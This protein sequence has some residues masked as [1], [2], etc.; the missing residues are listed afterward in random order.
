MSTAALAGVSLIATFHIL[1]AA[2]IHDAKKLYQVNDPIRQE[3]DNGGD[4]LYTLDVRV[5]GQA[6]KSI[7]DSG[8]FDL[9]VF[10]ARC[11]I[12]GVRRPYNDSLSK[13]YHTSHF[14]AQQTFGSGTTQ[15]LESFDVVEI[16]SMRVRRQ[17]F[18]EVNDADSGF[19]E[20]IFG[21]ILGIG[22]PASAAKIA[23][24]EAKSVS[25]DVLKGT[26]GEPSAITQHY[27]A[28]VDRTK[29]QSLF[30]QEVG[31][32]RF[33]ICLQPNSGSPGIMVW[34]DNAPITQPELFYTVD[35]L[36]DVYWST[37]LSSVRLS[38]STFGGR[39]LGCTRKSCTAVFDSGTSLLVIPPSAYQ[40]LSQMADKVSRREGCQDLSFLPDLVFH[41][42]GKDF[43]LPPESYMGNLSGVLSDQ[44]GALMPHARERRKAVGHSSCTLLLMTTE[45]MDDNA[46]WILGLPWFRKYYTTFELSEDSRKASRIHL[47]PA[48]SSC[49]PNTAEMGFTRTNSRGRNFQNVD[50]SKVRVPA[51][52]HRVQRRHFREAPET[53]D[54][55]GPL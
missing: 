48:D 14:V 43:S 27:Q 12:C 44:L 47:S 33:S 38:E 29:H 3:L 20:M 25:D 18:W 19:S 46:V 26:D 45:A 24:R 40:A 4:A 11:Q 28:V 34:N 52:V 6:V 39:Q 7:P 22:P 50:A 53:V 41:I 31:V 17:V 13:T 30:L 36:D 49:G 8:S 9:L 51:W 16:A 32:R 15:S 42:N 55:S 35:A 37:A 1:S 2:T 21:S 5:G 54:Y 23:E 10:S